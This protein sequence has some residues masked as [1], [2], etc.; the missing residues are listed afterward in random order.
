[1]IPTNKFNERITFLK[2]EKHKNEYFEWV[3]EYVPL[4]T[5]WCS[6]KQ[7]YFRE[8]VE[9]IGTVLE[10]TM[11]F[12]IRYD[13]RFEINQSMRIEFKGNQYEIINILEGSYARDFTTI[14]AKRV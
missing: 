3:E 10:N 6:I 13:Q 5:I 8:Y 12:S 14:V 2:L 7:Q 1:M 9:S 11:N 4:A